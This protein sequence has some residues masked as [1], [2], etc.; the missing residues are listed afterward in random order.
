MT[1][2]MNLHL[3]RSNLS[4]APALNVAGEAVVRS[5]EYSHGP[6][7]AVSLVL[8]ETTINLFV[9]HEGEAIALIDALA[10]ITETLRA[11]AAVAAM[12]R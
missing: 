8:D 2:S 1:T 5:H 10:R 4:D 12:A 7:V 11:F 9:H 6:Y 3:M